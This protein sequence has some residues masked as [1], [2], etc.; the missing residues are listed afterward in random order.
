MADGPGG[1]PER[2]RAFF[3]GGGGGTIRG[4]GR[5]A[6][7]GH[8]RRGA[9]SGGR[10]TS[11]S[12]TLFGSPRSADHRSR[13]ERERRERGGDQRRRLLST[14]Q[15]QQPVRRSPSSMVTDADDEEAGPIPSEANEER[16]RTSPEGRSAC[17]TG[18]LARIVR[19]QD[20]SFHLPDSSCLIFP[21][22][23][24]II[25]RGRGRGPMDYGR[26]STGQGSQ[27]LRPA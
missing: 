23:Q 2:S 22:S 6:S 11:L 13:K 10:P 16:N 9:R 17:L 15:G 5:R 19:R 4:D 1:R 14:P 12:P 7:P 18:S 8:D 21:E 20:I 27:R 24:L 26:R 25:Q 3:L